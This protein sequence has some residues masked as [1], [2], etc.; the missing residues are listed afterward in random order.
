MGKFEFVYLQNYIFWQ[1][2]N[3][4]LSEELCSHAIDPS[5]E[6]NKK[7]NNFFLNYEQN[8]ISLCRRLESIKLLVFYF[9]YLMQMTV[10]LQNKTILQPIQKQLKA[11]ETA[12]Y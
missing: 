5:Q 8:P 2:I 6:L 7:K 12:K 4:R 10:Q 1:K 11:E 9:I 3:F